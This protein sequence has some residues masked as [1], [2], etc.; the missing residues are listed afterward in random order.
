MQYSIIY[1]TRLKKSLKQ[2][3]SPD[4]KIIKKNI[5]KKLPNNPKKFG[6]PLKNTLKNHWSLRVGKYRV[7][8]EIKD[9]EVI[10]LFVTIAKRE[11]VYQNLKKQLLQ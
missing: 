6:K 3:S 2:I 9:K 5:E 7:V 10:V 1:D 11:N 4:L 8:Y